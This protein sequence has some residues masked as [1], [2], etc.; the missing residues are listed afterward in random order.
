M[1]TKLAVEA[2]TLLV[3]AEHRYYGDSMP[4]GSREAAMANAITLGYLTL[5]HALADF[6]MI[7][8][9]L[10]RILSA[11]N[12]PVIVYGSL[13]AGILATWFRLKYL[14]IAMASCGVSAPILY[15]RDLI[16]RDYIYCSQKIKSK[17]GLDR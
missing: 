1:V 12:C 15:N 9:N 5:S 2:K 16:T 7:I 13:Y 11:E 10:K 17:L 8:T 3:T 4:F 6:T 14:H